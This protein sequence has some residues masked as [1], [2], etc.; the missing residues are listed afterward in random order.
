MM[1]LRR[2]ET[3]VL[4]HRGLLDARSFMYLGI[5]LQTDLSLLDGSPE[6][7]SGLLS[8]IPG[9]VAPTVAVGM[10]FRRPSLAG[11]VDRGKAYC[12]LGVEEML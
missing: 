1:M 2:Q 10:G 3:A 7:I 11:L 12:A 8:S 6:G 5:G 4:E 9:P